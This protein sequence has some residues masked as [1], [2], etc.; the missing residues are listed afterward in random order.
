MLKKKKEENQTHQENQESLLNDK[1]MASKSWR[2]SF[3]FGLFLVNGVS[4]GMWL[5]GLWVSGGHRPPAPTS[6]NGWCVGGGAL[7]M[8]DL[9]KKRK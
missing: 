2:A 5:M 7:A 9:K 3:F 6:V 1:V 4:G 8:V